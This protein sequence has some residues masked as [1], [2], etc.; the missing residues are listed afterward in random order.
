MLQEQIKAMCEVIFL[1]FLQRGAKTRRKI[2]ASV[3]IIRERL[4]SL[5]KKS[6]RECIVEVSTLRDTLRQIVF[7]PSTL[8]S[9]RGTRG[10]FASRENAKKH[11]LSAIS[12]SKKA[13]NKFYF[14]TGVTPK[15]LLSDILILLS[16]NIE[17]YEP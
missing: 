12:S 8:W 2:S 11:V 5:V 1:L 3:I 13:I 6:R 14:R 7:G 10:I 15:N 4:C 17:E 9:S 16:R